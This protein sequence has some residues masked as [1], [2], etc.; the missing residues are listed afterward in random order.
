MNIIYLLRE[1]AKDSLFGMREA[2]IPA[3]ITGKDGN[4]RGQIKNVVP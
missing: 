1:R 4:S 3:Y 2:R